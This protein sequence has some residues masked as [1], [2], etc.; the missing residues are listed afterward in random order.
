MKYVIYRTCSKMNIYYYLQGHI[1]NSF[2][3]D[4]K[5]KYFNFFMYNEINTY[6][7]GLPKASSWIMECV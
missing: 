7:W 4:I 1:K 5:E 3:N 6:Y 2:Y